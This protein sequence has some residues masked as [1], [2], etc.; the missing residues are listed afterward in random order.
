MYAKNVNMINKT[1][2]LALRIPVPVYHCFC[3]EEIIIVTVFNKYQ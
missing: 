1:S 2:N 3:M